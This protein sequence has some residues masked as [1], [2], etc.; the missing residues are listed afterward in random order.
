[1]D[2]TAKVEAGSGMARQAGEALGEIVA[3]VKKVADLIAEIS[4]AA[5]E[6]ALGIEQVNKAVIQMDSVTQQNAAQ[7]HRFSSIAKAVATQAMELQGQLDQFKLSGQVIA[8][9]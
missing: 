5:Q 4:A 1:M 9:G 8:P 7:T 3:G 2:A 6:Q